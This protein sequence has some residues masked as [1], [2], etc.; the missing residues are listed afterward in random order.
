MS[1]LLRLT[2]LRSRKS[3]ILL[4]TS[5]A[6]LDWF[7]DDLQ[8]HVTSSL[9]VLTQTRWWLG[10]LRPDRSGDSAWIACRGTP[11]SRLCCAACLSLA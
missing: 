4:K 7:E 5:D 1:R 10:H 9:A 8:P 3:S 6:L 2:R 11:Q